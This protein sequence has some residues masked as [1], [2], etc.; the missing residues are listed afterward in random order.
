MST[1]SKTEST[2]L[3][4]H[5]DA[6]RF[7]DSALRFTQKRLGRMLE[8]NPELDEE[9]AHISGP[10]LLDGIRE[11]ARK[12]FGLLTIPVFRHWGVCSTDDFGHIVFDFI[13]RGAM[14]KTDQDQLSDF[15]AVYDFASVFDVDYRIDL[16]GAFSD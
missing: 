13:E 10:E 12:E 1:L 11:L 6:Y 15:F 14:K 2:E 5:T 16:S 7:V 9:T 3:K 8:S 4:Y